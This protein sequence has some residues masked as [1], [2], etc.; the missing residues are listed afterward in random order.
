MEAI[1]LLGVVVA[2]YFAPTFA[3]LS[4]QHVNAVPILIVNLF[5]GWTLI[6]WV[7]CLAWAYSANGKSRV[8]SGKKR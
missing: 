2:I 7:A 1:I 3:A 8:A 5:F 4:R 6:G